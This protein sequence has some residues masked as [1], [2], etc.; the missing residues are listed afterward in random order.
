MRASGV[1]MPVFSLPSHYGIGCFSRE[2]Y[3]FIFRLEE[4]KQKYWQ[5]LP[6]GPTGAGDS[7]YAP[8]SSFALN[9]YF[10][11]P[12]VLVRKG[13]LDRHDFSTRDFGI[14][15]R[16]IDYGKLF[17]G[18]TDLLR[19]A[20]RGFSPTPDFETFKSSNAG[21]L[22]DYSLFMAVKE[23]FDHISWS[24]W[25]KDIM[26]RKQDA[27]DRYS[28]ILGKDIEFFKWEQ[29]ELNL[30]WTA[31]KHHANA[32][33]VEIIGDL[34]IYTAFDSADCWANSYLFML[35]RNKRPLSVAGCPPDEYAPRG[36]L[37]GNP[38]YNWNSIRRHSY[39]WWISRIQHN[40][41]L[42]DIVRLDHYR[43]F[44][45]FYSIKSGET[46][47]V[48]GRW[49]AGPGLPFFNYVEKQ[50]GKKRYIAEDLGFIDES[51]REM[52]TKN[53]LPGMKVLQFA[54]GGD[55]SEYLPHNYIKNCIVYT[56]THDN[57]TSR[58]WFANLEREKRH[59]LRAYTGRPEIAG[60]NIAA[61]MIRLAESSIADTCIIPI[62]DW[63][64]LGSDSR[65]N[66]PGTAQGNWRW[67]MTYSEFTKKLA[68]R[69]ADMAEM[70]G[71]TEW[72]KKE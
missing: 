31:L 34:P 7:P 66:I 22:D 35:D 33:G 11:D 2:A 13:L 26:L 57:D 62:Q 37:W 51:V 64:N 9:P 69:M 18:R 50:I 65:I 68:D 47:A 61:E 46:T 63:L 24:E 53:G 29:Y 44:E 10:I 30:E 38:I 32:H 4:A 48:N 60:D 1:L 58:G 15:S 54:F 42:F 71:R 27:L 36:Q 5:I 40:F 67:R 23:H 45:S 55:N 72:M 59:W 25:D 49:I 19:I 56:G 17:A 52:I 70:Y 39:R 43:G 21:W 12:A 3:E 28:E 20:Y 41:R 8:L 16:Y 14:D 6:L